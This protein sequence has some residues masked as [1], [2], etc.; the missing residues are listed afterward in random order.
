MSARRQAASAAAVGAVL[1][2]SAVLL[3]WGLLW[4]R[5]GG[6]TGRTTTLNVYF[7]E[8]G[9]RLGEGNA[10][11][12][13]GVPVGTVALVAPV[14]RPSIMA[15]DELHP[16]Q[17]TVVLVQCRLRS[18][19]V[20]RDSYRVRVDASNLVGDSFVDI[21][22][23]SESGT[24]VGDG[25]CLVGAS[26]L[27]LLSVV[28]TAE[29]SLAQVGAVASELNRALTEED[30]ANQLAL[31]AKATQEAMGEIARLARELT[32]LTS[33]NAQQVTT[34]VRRVS[35]LTGQ[36]T[37][38]TARLTAMLSEDGLAGE[39][40]TA[41]REVA[42][43]AGSIASASAG[44]ERLLGSEDNLRAIEETV[45]SFA[46]TSTTL[47]RVSSEV[48]RLLI[49]DK[50]IERVGDTLDAALSAARGLDELTATLNRLTAGPLGEQT[51][52]GTVALIQQASKDLSAAAKRVIE[53]LDEGRPG[54]RA[55]SI[56]DRMERASQGSTSGSSSD[57]A[58]DIRAA[59]AAARQIGDDLGVASAGLTRLLTDGGFERD[60]DQTLGAM[61]EISER[62]AAL[63]RRLE[64][65]QQASVRDDAAPPV[66]P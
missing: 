37:G 19:V 31:A 59:A 2:G 14:E 60:L 43:T 24:P 7:W 66:A 46:R 39:A 55:E 9:G 30:L 41:L 34:T 38:V 54:G 1:I 6:Y 12:L 50:G 57:T 28:P 26:P 3:V 40:R 48:D 16:D 52:I 22:P 63:A 36:L 29:E 51:L 11:R 64:A 21:Q 56:L 15:P 25:G 8:I 32:A 49:E 5:G 10:V 44:L 61:R 23:V 13:A 47:E 33:A 35:E 42:R 27:D 65:A 53:V 58:D 62:L 4:L 17:D 45:R 18:G 20:V